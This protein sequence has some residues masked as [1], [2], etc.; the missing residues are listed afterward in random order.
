MYP[1][2]G[3]SYGHG[4]P[5][6]DPNDPVSQR[7]TI[8]RALNAARITW[9]YYCQDDSVFLANWAD[10]NDPEIQGKVRNISEWY[11]ILAS[12]SADQDLPQVVFIEGAASSGCDEHPGNNVQEGAARVQQILT[13][14]LTSTA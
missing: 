6:S 3:T 11:N 2:A 9:R 1:F 14:L 12:P 5:V 7:P 10:W 13:G 4:Y 8:F